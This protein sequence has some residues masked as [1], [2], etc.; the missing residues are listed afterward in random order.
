MSYLGVCVCVCFCWNSSLLFIHTV[1]RHIGMESR[2]RWQCT[3]KRDTHA[4][5][6]RKKSPT[7]PNSNNDKIVF[8]SYKF[9]WVSLKNSQDLFIWATELEFYW[10]TFFELIRS[11]E[12]SSSE[13]RPLL[14]LIIVA[15][16]DCKT[17]L[18]LEI[19]HKRNI[20][21]LI[22]F[23]RCHSNY[24][25]NKAIF[26]FWC[27][28]VGLFIGAFATCQLPWQFDEWYALQ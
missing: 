14:L 2:I 22:V 5:R 6:T 11:E 8:K 19:G 9:R 28:S 1:T 4:A 23:S 18:F 3:I 7:H 21:H 27:F 24:L 16:F 12:W 25:P 26:H 17:F 13:K 15:I 20:P 10:Y